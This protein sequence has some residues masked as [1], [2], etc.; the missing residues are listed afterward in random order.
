MLAVMTQPFST[1]GARLRTLREAAGLS[2][3]ELARQMGIRQSSVSGWEAGR[4]TPQLN[5]AARLAQALGV[6]IGEL[7]TPDLLAAQGESAE[8]EPKGEEQ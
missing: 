7:M 6:K 8:D 3:R 2:Q 1:F 4:N 5:L